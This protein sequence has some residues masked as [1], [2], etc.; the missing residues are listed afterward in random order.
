LAADLPRL[1]FS[2]T[3]ARSSAVFVNELH[4]SRF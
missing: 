3:H 1:W 2:Q 4:S